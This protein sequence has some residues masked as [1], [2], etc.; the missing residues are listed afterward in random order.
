[1]RNNHQSSVSHTNDY[2]LLRTSLRA[3]LL[4]WAGLSHL[5]TGWL[6]NTESESSEISSDELTGNIQNTKFN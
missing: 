4:V 5:F 6:T 2:F 1:M 3:V